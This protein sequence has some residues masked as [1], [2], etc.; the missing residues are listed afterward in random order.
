MLRLSESDKQNL[1]ITTEASDLTTEGTIIRAGIM[2]STSNID[3]RH[4]EN[5]Q[6]RMYI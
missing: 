4:Q 6:I 2:F 5:T 1:Y 3:K